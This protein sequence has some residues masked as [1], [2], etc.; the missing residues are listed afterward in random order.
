LYV[1]CQTLSSYSSAKVLAQDHRNDLLVNS[2]G[3]AT[4]I[5]GSR[6]AGW[7]DAVGSILIALIILRSW[8]STLFGTLDYFFVAKKKKGRKMKAHIFL[9]LFYISPRKYTPCCWKKCRY[10]VS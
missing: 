4:G 1:Y 9:T 7:V 3:L 5:V 6:V 2:L 8:I 10:T